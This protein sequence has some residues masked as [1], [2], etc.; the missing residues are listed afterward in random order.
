MHSSAPCSP[1]RKTVQAALRVAASALAFAFAVSP[2]LALILVGKGNAPVQDPGWPAGAIEVA[3]Q[4]TRVGW[5]EGP[6]FGGGQWTFFYRGDTA[7]L[8]EALAKFSA[9]KAERLEVVLHEGA[10]KSGFLNDHGR[11]NESDKFDW[12]FEVW[13]PANFNQLY[14][15]TNSVFTSSQPNFRKPVSAPRLDVYLRDGGPDW[16]QLKPGANVTVRDARATAN[17]FPA[18]SG[19][20]VRAKVTDTGGKPIPG[21]RLIAATR[22]P[23]A[24]DYEPEKSVETDAGGTA[25]MTKLAEGPYRMTVEAAGFA[26]RLI[27]YGTYG[28]NVFREYSV[29]LAPVATLAGTVFDE[30]GQPLAGARI[31]PNHT[32]TADGS[33][34]PLAGEVE[35]LS[36]AQGRFALTNLPAGR[37][38]VWASLKDYHHLWHPRDLVEV[39]AGATTSHTVRME[40]TGAIRVQLVDAD[41]NPLRGVSPGS[42]HVFIQE[43]DKAGVGSW[44]GSAQVNADGMHEFTGVPPRRF[45]VS[46]TSFN[47]KPAN[48]DSQEVVVAVEPGKTTEVKVRAH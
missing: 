18:G 2:A 33:G 36:D 20:V 48:Q 6:P 26:P 32:M 5:M 15:N 42:K 40:R 47:D 10:G 8:R 30:A 7:A 19:S 9:I 4:L 46:G 37:M 3:N 39:P 27:E 29:V 38:Q 35:V 34:D 21:A 25:V 44:G 12:S 28:A 22:A 14:N 43:A 1:P 41:G 11:S 45:R 17:G 23:T 13:V 31:R 16:K 24:K